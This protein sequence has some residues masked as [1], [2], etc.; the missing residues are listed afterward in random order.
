MNARRREA[1]L[2]QAVGC[3]A[4]AVLVRRCRR[5]VMLHRSRLFVISPVNALRHLCGCSTTLDKASMS[6]LSSAEP[7]S[8]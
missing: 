3:A 7:A 4:Q 5:A 8:R 1:W 2:P 6:S